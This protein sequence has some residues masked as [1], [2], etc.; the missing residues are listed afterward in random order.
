M[1]PVWVK[2]LAPLWKGAAPI[3]LR[4]IPLAVVFAVGFHVGSVR[5]LGKALERERVASEDAAAAEQALRAEMAAQ[6]EAH[7]QHA[8]EVAYRMGV[9]TMAAAARRAVATAQRDA[10]IET[11]VKEVHHRVR[12]ECPKQEEGDPD[13]DRGRL[14][15]EWRVLHDQAVAAANADLPAAAPDAADRSGDSATADSVDP[16]EALGAVIENYRRAGANADALTACQKSMRAVIAAC[17]A[18]TLT[19]AQ[20]GESH[21][22][23]VY[24]SH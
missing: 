12:V 16:A 10:R 17:W 7:A 13:A 20:E 24:P 19:A 9:E 6:A 15:G 22:Q 11:I 3:L 4:A 1:I 2:S 8:A 14:S 23:E 18:T 21:E 5:E